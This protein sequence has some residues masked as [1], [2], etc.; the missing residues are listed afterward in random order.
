[1]PNLSEIKQAAAELLA[2]FSHMRF[3]CGFQILK[4]VASFRNCRARP[5]LGKISK[6]LLTP[7]KNWGGYDASLPNHSA[8][9]AT[10]VENRGRIL[11]HLTP[12]VKL[13][14]WVCE[15]SE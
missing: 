1:M 6:Y 2:T 5:K 14:E 8:S 9:K 15:M 4:H 11:H 3:R 12:P 13:S 7:C 10:G